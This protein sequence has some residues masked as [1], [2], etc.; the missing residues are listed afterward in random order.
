MG[1]EPPYGEIPR[2]V[3]PPGGTED[4]RHGTQTLVRLGVVVPTHWGSAGYGGPGVYRSI[5]FPMPE[6]GR[7]IHCYQSYHGRVFGGIAESGNVP[8]HA[9]VGVAC[10]GYYGD[11]GGA[12]SHVGGG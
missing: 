2:G 9:M 6:H 1:I 3:S 11:Q 7:A 4:G 8:I 5:Y 12:G 10:P